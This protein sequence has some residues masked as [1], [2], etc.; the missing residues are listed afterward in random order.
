MDRVDAVALGHVTTD[1]CSKCGMTVVDNDGC[2][3]DEV[4]V[5]KMQV[6]QAIAKMAGTGFS[7]ALI[8]QPV[9]SFL[10]TPVYTD[11]LKAE[12]VAHGPPL[13]RQDTY[14]Q[15]CVFRI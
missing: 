4:K 14:L 9:T 1:E 2:C 3:K 12:P 7:P 5:L 11:F 6:D 10:Y 15:N 13:S 8:P